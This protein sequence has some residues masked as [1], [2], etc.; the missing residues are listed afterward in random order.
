MNKSNLAVQTIRAMVNR[1]KKEEGM[2][3]S[4]AFVRL[5]YDLLFGDESKYEES[6]T[7]GPGDYGVDIIYF[8]ERDG[9]FDVYLVQCK[10]SEKVIKASDVQ[11][12]I[13]FYDILTAKE[14]PKTSNPII[15]SQIETYHELINSGM[16]PVNFY[17]YTA[18]LSDD[19]SPEGR[20]KVEILLREN[21]NVVYKHIGVQELRKRIIAQ[22]EPSPTVELTLCGKPFEYHKSGTTAIIGNV[23]AKELAIVYEKYGETIFSKNV[24][25]FLGSTNVNKE[26]LKTLED[27]ETNELFW[28][29]YN[30]LT[31]V[32][33]SYQREPAKT[34]PKVKIE[35]FQIVNGTQTTRSIYEAYK[36]GIDL[37][38]VHVLAKILE[39]KN[40]ILGSKIAEATNT[41][42]PIKKRDL[43]SNDEVQIL[44]EKG[45]KQLGYYY[46]RKRKQFVGV[47][48]KKLIDNEKFAQ[49]CGAFIF[50]IPAEVRNKK[51]LLFDRE[52]F[53]YKIF[54]EN[55]TPG[56]VLF[57][58]KIAEKI[59]NILRDLQKNKPEIIPTPIKESFWASRFHILY[60]LGLYLKEMGYDIERAEYFPEDRSSDGRIVIENVNKEMVIKC[61]NIV[62]RAL[63]SL[64]EDEEVSQLLKKPS[65]TE[66]IRDLI[67]GEFGD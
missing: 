3:V 2:T 63:K 65:L 36:E 34:N 22:E 48:R 30:G 6:I 45:L 17:L 32:C 26:I 14:T 50:G 66:K 55:L 13:N 64:Q 31:I 62:N 23:D 67:E 51:S 25:Y 57:V 20:E 43:R 53:Y 59:F 61:M 12:L 27:E 46:Q 4:Q 11:N 7:E 18:S 54:N 37:S 49:E 29:L 38:G 41:Q 40:E 39:T 44:L 47:P 16:L 52:G 60:A 24:R 10:Y 58:H 5:V 42:N 9:K 8:L 19:V 56:K 1:I 15:K 35:G 28:F 21:Q 33:K